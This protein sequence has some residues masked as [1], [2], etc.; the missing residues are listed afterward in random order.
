MPILHEKI[1]VNDHCE[2]LESP[3]GEDDGVACISEDRVRQN[4]YAT[5]DLN[6]DIT[7]V[8]HPRSMWLDKLLSTNVD[9]AADV[10]TALAR[11]GDI[12]HGSAHS[13]TQGVSHT[14]EAVA[15]L[16]K[17][18]LELDRNMHMAEADYSTALMQILLSELTGKG[19]LL[20]GVPEEWTT[21]VGVSDGVLPWSI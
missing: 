15:R 20:V 17:S 10:Y 1:V 8:S 5:R 12:A 2:A 3:C 11:A 16:C 6:L 9:D 19:D 18:H 14:H 21:S 4:L 7:A 13:S